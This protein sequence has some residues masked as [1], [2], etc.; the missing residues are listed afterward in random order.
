LAATETKMPAD[1]HLAY[2]PGAMVSV[3]TSLDLGFL[4][5]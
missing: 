2:K 4:G 5:D 1:Y 3:V